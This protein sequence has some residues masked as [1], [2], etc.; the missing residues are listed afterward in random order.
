MHNN[1]DSLLEDEEIAQSDIFDYAIPGGNNRTYET[2]LYNLNVFN[3]RELVEDVQI[4]DCRFVSTP[5]I[6]SN[7][8]LIKILTRLN[9]FAFFKFNKTIS[10][11]PFTHLRPF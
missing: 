1:I 5:I 7:F 6:I 10:Q 4:V 11:S 3:H 9:S 8:N 2:A